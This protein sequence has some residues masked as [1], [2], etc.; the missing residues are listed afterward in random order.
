M[1]GWK[2]NAGTD[3]CLTQ[4]ERQVKKLHVAEIILSHSVSYCQPVLSKFLL[5]VY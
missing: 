1:R 5:G 3:V 2:A 4:V